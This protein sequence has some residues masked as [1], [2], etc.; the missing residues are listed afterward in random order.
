MRKMEF[1]VARCLTEDYVKWYK[2]FGDTGMAYPA[3]DEP[4]QRHAIFSDGYKRKLILS[5]PANLGDCFYVDNRY[6]KDKKYP[7]FNSRIRDA[8]YAV[9]DGYGDLIY[10]NG[11]IIRVVYILD[12]QKGE[13]LRAETLKDYKDAKF[14]YCIILGFKNGSRF[15]LLENYEPSGSD[16]YDIM[17]F[18]T[19][20][21]A[22]EFVNTRKNKAEELL[23]LKLSDKI[24]QSEIDDKLREIDGGTD[25]G[26][27]I[28]FY[29]AMYN[30]PIHTLDDY[31]IWYDQIIL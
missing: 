20:K 23:K 4:I 19:L 24:G 18:A 29:Y 9:R 31:G 2:E 7:T 27:T 1:R 13:E 6:N 30:S 10:Q 8:V 16:G 28:G 5:G 26:I 21:E 3:K 14:G 17:K 22:E 25:V 15:P 12:R 11:R